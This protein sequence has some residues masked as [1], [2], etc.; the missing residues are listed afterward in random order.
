MA[1]EKK[2][3]KRRAH[4]GAWIFIKIQFVL[5]GLVVLALAW[6]YLG[7][8]ARKVAAM[9]E[10]AVQFVAASTP[11]TF[12]QSQTSLAYDINGS[13]ISV[14]KGEK[15]VYYLTIDEIPEYAKQAIIS[16]EDKKFYTH[17]GVDYRAILRAI[18]AMVQNGEV[19]QGASTITQ[20]L[21]R[22]VFL[23]NDKTWERKVEE[24][25][26]A[27]ELEKKYSKDQILEYYMNNVYFANGNYGIEA[28]SLGYFNMEV[29]N[30]SLSQ[31]AFL[32]AIP[33]RPSLYDP[34]QHMD[35]TLARRNRILQNM[36]EDGVISVSSYDT[37]LA[38]GITL[39][40]PPATNTHTDAESFMMYCATRA[41]MV[42]DGFEFK[43]DFGGE[44]EKSVYEQAYQEAY[45]TANASLFSG[46]YRIYT[47][48][49]L[50]VQAAL[51][52]AID[53]E[54]SFS[55]ETGSDGVYAL[56]GA[57]VCID[58]ST[59]YVKAAVGGRTQ[60][61]ITGT[62]LNRAYQA[63]RQPGS[64]IKPLLVYTP[65]LEQGMTKD[66]IVYDEP[67][68]DGPENA[69]RSY[70]GAMTLQRA[71]EVSKNT[72]A[73]NLFSILTP[74]KGIQYLK[75]LGFYG[76]DHLDE[77]PA[78]SIG[79]FAH[80]PSPLEMAKGYAALEHDGAAR[81][82]TCIIKITDADGNEIVSPDRTETQVYK[83]SAARQM[84]EIL[85]GVMI[86]GTAH[87]RGI[88][89]MPT[90]GK[91][92]TTSDSK[93]GWFCGY[94]AYYTTSIWIGYDTPRSMRGLSGST[95]PLRVWDNFMVPLHKGLTPIEFLKPA[96]VSDNPGEA[97]NEAA[98]EG[99]AA[100]EAG[101]EAGGAAG[102]AGTAG[103]TGGAGTPDAAGAAGDAAAP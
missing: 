56:Q 102:D 30:L 80:G 71:V 99:P 58:N 65:M 97:A 21:A 81:E 2:E 53:K 57:G 40:V 44:A 55:G 9:H 33:N 77:V 46:G 13:V 61:N 35:N 29:S 4:R 16:I 91:T 5:M 6:Y 75:N 1:K 19:T 22:N 24:I 70:A 41:I 50:N 64:A 14:L 10:E 78:A 95:Y 34:I 63:H 42:R 83:E 47:S 92:G 17:H 89:N 88:P 27:V 87:G 43:N 3:K 12:R 39:N 93:D 94:T 51:Q 18:I 90:A 73:W 48:L 8:S 25:Y 69:D 23:T 68:E 26:I 52:A 98:A 49:D 67:I 74:E 96:E 84:T 79:G 20:Q 38:E 59:G 37:A 76:L 54:L 72:V 31:I 100:E 45:N 28:A 82:A 36:L 15:D 66:T 60:N 101:A 86:N 62:K 103:G 7:G 11:D 32:C 85:E